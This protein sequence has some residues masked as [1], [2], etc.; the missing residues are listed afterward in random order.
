MQDQPSKT[1]PNLWMMSS[2]ILAGIIIGFGIA[3]LPYFGDA[4]TQTSVVGEQDPTKPTSPK[5]E[6]KA[7]TDEQIT[8]L[9]DDDPVSGESGATITFVEFSDF[10]CPYCARFTQNTVKQIKENYVKTGKVK[11]IFRDFPLT[12][13]KNAVPAAVAS[14]C[15]NEQNKYWEMHDAL[16]NNQ[17]LWSE[18]AKPTDLFKKYAKELG[19]DAQ[20]FNTCLDSNKFESEIN[21]DLM[22]GLAYGIN[23]TPG[24]FIN[25]KEV[26]EYSWCQNPWT[27]KYEWQ[28]I[29]GAMPYE[30]VFKPIIEAELADKKWEL[31]IEEGCEKVSVK[32][33]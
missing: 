24:S 14:E 12:M 8:K 32:T 28:K 33:F 6:I 20:K 26:A 5:P 4:D 25:G 21:K 18:D 22:D 31:Q 23:G 19:L 13:H 2:L 11:M 30:T 9:P 3:Q 29:S 15:A 10:E 17:K 27:Q 16:F 1:K 7:L